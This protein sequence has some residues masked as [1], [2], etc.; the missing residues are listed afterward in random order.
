MSGVSKANGAHA[1]HWADRIRPRDVGTDA[2]G[3]RDQGN[4]RW[5]KRK[6]SDLPALIAGGSL[7]EPVRCRIRDSS[8]SGAR[9]LLP[10]TQH[11]VDD[12]PDSFTLFQTNNREYTQ[13]KCVV[14]RRFGDSIGVRFAGA[15]TTVVKERSAMRAGPAKRR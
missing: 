11:T 2:A 8:S 1:L 5:A 14:I 9:L 13:V 15:F 6:R 10:G 7:P 3:G 12:I 4:Q